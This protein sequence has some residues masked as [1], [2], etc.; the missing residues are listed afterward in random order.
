[1]AE[2]FG[3][4]SSAAGIV[5]LI[6][7]LVYVCTKGYGM[8]RDTRNKMRLRD[9]DI[10]GSALFGPNSKKH[11]LVVKTL[12]KIGMFPQD[13]RVQVEPRR[14]RKHE[15]RRAT[16]TKEEGFQVRRTTI[17][18]TLKALEIRGSI[19]AAPDTSTNHNS[20]SG[21]NY[22][23]LRFP[24]AKILKT[25]P[26]LSQKDEAEVRMAMEGFK[27]IA[28][29][30][31]NEI[32]IL[33]KVR[34]AL[35]GKEYLSRALDDLEKYNDSLF[36]ITKDLGQ[37]RVSNTLSTNFKEFNVRF[38][39]PFR[40]NAI[41]CDR[42]DILERL[43]Q[44]LEPRD[45]V[46][47]LTNTTRT[48]VH[49]N[50]SRK[51]AILHGIGSIGKSQIALRFADRFSHCYSSIFWIDAND[52]SR[53]TESATMVVE[54]LV[55]HYKTKWRS[56]PNYQEIANTLGIPEHLDSSGKI[57]QSISLPAAIIKAVH[58]WLCVTENRGWLLLVDNHD[59][60]A[61]GE[62]DKLLPPCNWGSVVV[63]TRLANLHRFGECVEME[64]IGVEAG[65]DLLLKS[66]RKYRQNLDDSQ[67]CEARK[68]VKALGELPLA[69]DQAGA[70]ISSIQMS[71]SDYRKIIE[72][73]IRAGLNKQVPQYGLPSYKASVFTTWKLSFQE[74]DDNARRLLHL[75]AFLSN[76]DIPD[77]LFRR[78]RSGVDWI[79]E[80]FRIF[81]SKAQKL[82]Q[83]LLD[84]FASAC[85]AREH[86]DIA[87]QRQIAVDA[88]TL[89]ASAIYTNPHE[90]S[91]DDWIFER[92]ILSHLGVCRAH[93][94]RYFDG[95]DSIKAA[96]ASYD[97]AL[98]YKDLG[99]Y[100]YAETYQKAFALYEKALGSD[101]KSTLDTVHCMAIVFDSQGRYDEALEW[102]GRALAGYKRALGSEHLLTLKTVNNMAVVFDIQGRYDEALEW[103]GRA[104][105]GSEKAR[106]A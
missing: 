27:E 45:L 31:Q 13:R 89:V 66:S 40:Q 24:S 84:T 29:R 16:K 91:F 71:F 36:K 58:T 105:V 59:Q 20:A 46:E 38:T 81:L 2:A 82:N 35:S 90:K 33:K 8:L 98:A 72:K 106:I 28:Q 95:S 3:L 1:M 61:L 7:V 49:L 18:K 93:I 83:K 99:Y 64:E 17:T 94:S 101:H 6:P 57:N 53:T 69:L 92:R 70:H 79:S 48:D 62:L 50:S 60:V 42:D 103:Y 73:S 68:I 12:A 21:T 52:S 34:W 44:I 25:L 75:C 15:D 14:R 96:E 85:V 102:Y 56:C 67:L 88:I 76:E 32:S 55:D 78:G 10:D 87:T 26:E 39:L 9:E 54:Q 63:T 65:L 41:F 51:T 43:C 80:A 97:I 47:P 74:L 30:F 19:A 4:V 37:F 86:T 22:E 11:T 100:K 104:L 77:E 5:A 23:N